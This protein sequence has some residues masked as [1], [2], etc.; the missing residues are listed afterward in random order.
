MKDLLNDGLINNDASG[1]TQNNI[2]VSSLPPDRINIDNG[3]EASQLNIYMYQATYNQG[4][5]NVAQPSF[6]TKGERVSNPP[7]ALDLHYL[8]T[9]YGASELHT[10]ILLGMGMQFMHETPVLGRD[11]INIATG[12][13]Q[14]GNPGNTLPDSLRFLAQASLAD[15]VEQIK[16]SA[17]GLSVEDIS[18]LWA[19]FGTKYRPTAAYKVTVVLIESERSTKPGLPVQNRNI[20]VQPFK[21]PVIDTILS[22]SAVSQPIIEQQKI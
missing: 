18:K 4:W 2:T 7:L 12:S 3:S 21:L 14:I 11:Q 8:L 13:I 15:Q 5:R 1:I 6:N 22:Q 16:I 9:A 17:E 19:A 10:D 20:Y